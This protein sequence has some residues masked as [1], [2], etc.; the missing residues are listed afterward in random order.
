MLKD[1]EKD[2]PESLDE[3]LG[4][5]DSPSERTKQSFSVIRSNVDIDTLNSN[6]SVLVSKIILNDQRHINGH[7]S[8]L[9][10]KIEN[11]G[12]IILQYVPLEMR[13]EMVR[14]KRL[15][16]LIHRAVPR[17]PLLEWLYDRINKGRNRALSRAEVWGRLQYCGFDVIM[18]EESPWGYHLLARKQFMPSH[19]ENPSHYPIV[20]LDRVGYGGEII[21]IH[22]IRTMHSYSEF[23]QRKVFNMYSMKSTGKF[24]EDF[25]IT[26][27]GKFLRKYWLD[28]IPQALDWFR[29]N[30]KIVGIRAMSLHYF[31]LYPE[32][33]Q[34][35]YLKVKP[36]F[37]SPIFD[38]NNTNFENIVE[39]EERYLN[40]Y[41][42]RPMVTDIRYFLTTISDIFLRGI[43]SN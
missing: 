36:G 7:L 23:I 29:G 9:Y 28:E 6:N 3:L 2:V 30:I 37:I 40:N 34:R 8:A 42:E 14:S 35:S 13:R 33:Y 27:W 11:G 10:N 5:G 12:Y 26:E 15:D 17:L 4:E 24:K 21:K 18:E 31:S 25:R 39:T 19:V 32:R 41:L 43:R 16:F 20:K 38:E 22:K 1:I